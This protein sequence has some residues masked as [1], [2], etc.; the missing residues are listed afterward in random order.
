[1]KKKIVGIDIPP[2]SETFFEFQIR[3]CREM[4]NEGCG[5]QY[6]ESVMTAYG[7]DIVYEALQSDLESRR[8]F[9]EDFNA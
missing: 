3:L 5:K 6:I 1:M 4:L 7:K 9:L 8:L 2:E